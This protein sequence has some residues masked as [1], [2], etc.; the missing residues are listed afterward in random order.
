MLTS[1]RQLLIIA[2]TAQSD[3]LLELTDLRVGLLDGE[4]LEEHLAIIQKRDRTTG[5]S[6]GVRSGSEVPKL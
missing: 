4:Q 6:L 2:I 5:A 3:K 1:F